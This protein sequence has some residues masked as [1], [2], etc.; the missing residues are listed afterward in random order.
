MRS[1]L[2]TS[3]LHSF[4][5]FACRP[6]D[7]LLQ[8]LRC[9]RGNVA[10]TFGLGAIPMLIAAGTAID[11]SRAY[12]VKQQ[13]GF[14]LDSAGL[15]A[16]SSTNPDQDLQALAQAYFTA[17]YPST[18]FGTPTMS[19]FSASS[20]EINISGSATLPT[21]FMQIV[22]IDQLTV[23]ASAT[24][25]RQTSGLELVMALDNTGSMSSSGKLAAMQSAA[26]EMINTLF[27]SETE[28]AL[29]KVGLVPFSHTVNI[30]PSNTAYVSSTSAY[31]WGT[32]SWSGCVMARTYPADVQDTTTAAGGLWAPY[33]WADNND[34]N[35][36]K[37][38]STYSIVVG[39]PSTKG[40]NKQ[41]PRAITPLTNNKTTL[42]SEISAMWA[43]GNTHINE[44]AAWAWRVISPEAPFTEG[45]A[46]G[47]E[48]WNKAVVILT[49]GDNTTSTSVYSAYGYRN[50][51]LLG[52]TSGS[53]TEAALDSRLQ[54]VCTG[55]KAA[56]IKV[57]T[58]SFGTGVS[59][60]SQTM[61]S[62]CAT[63]ATN[64]YHA[65]DAATIKKAF[66]AIGAELKKLHL[67][68]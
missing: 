64:Y 9:R 23:H 59:S 1:T 7:V 17:N 28:P 49:D 4:L 31:D 66:R 58:I 45:T 27:G 21:T 47:T 37:S 22:G 65:P 3:T 33:Y 61:L 48:N 57:Y 32:T 30:G 12:R 44:G 67:S 11:L 54:E 55:M 13:L 19:S 46:Y 40:P 42:L 56:G 2:L 16:G 39:P 36:W 50:S 14:A 62:N 38:G 34:Y 29:L 10:V 53:C 68:K 51:G 8:L 6:L 24:I 35:N 63:A 18:S 52:C 25:Q 41:C 20:S 43:S 60:A 5:S 26:T 15:A